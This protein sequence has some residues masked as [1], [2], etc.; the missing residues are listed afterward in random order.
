[1]GILYYTTE[2]E[3]SKSVDAIQKLLSLKWAKSISIDYSEG[4]PVALC[5][6]IGAM[7]KAVSFRLPYNWDGVE[8][9]RTLDRKV[10]PRYKNRAQAKRVAWRIVKDWIE[11]QIAI[12]ESGQALIQEVFLPYA[13]TDTGQTIFERSNQDFQRMLKAGGE[14]DQQRNVIVGNLK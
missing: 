6:K 7:G 4:E 5:F 12:I 11:A 14:S 1:M 8:K 10:P 2:V 9:S 3:V 13:I